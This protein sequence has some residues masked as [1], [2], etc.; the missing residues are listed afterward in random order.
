[1]LPRSLSHLSDRALAEQLE[2]LVSRERVHAA[3]LLAHLAEFDAR[4]LYRPAGYA[5][6]YVYC[7]KALG[8]SEDVACRRTIAARASR[9]HPTILAAL[10]DGRLHLSAVVT[11]APYLKRLPRQAA[12]ALLEAAERRSKHDL[13]LM[14][15]TRFPSPDVPT[16]VR[17]VMPASDPAATERA[18]LTTRPDAPTSGSALQVTPMSCT[19]APA[20]ISDVSMTSAPPFGPPS[21]AVPPQPPPQQ[22]RAQVVPLSAERFE[23]RGTI[24]CDFHEKIQKLRELFSHVV[25]NGD[26]FA[27]LERCADEVL[28]RAERRG[29]TRASRVEADGT[30]LAIDPE[31]RQ[32]PEALRR[33]IWHRDGGQCTFV[34]ESGRRCESRERVELDHVVPVAKGGRTEAGNLRLLC[35]THNQF[36]AERQLGPEFIRQRRAHAAQQREFERASERATSRPA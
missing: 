14:L 12:V 11:L 25:P 17:P 7:V 9:R 13:A 27:L 23:L 31:H 15:A 3:E 21:L 24:S 8:M 29:T 30:P 34:S 33:F 6:L 36:E 4:K 20:R 32:A 28:A 18:P 16:S 2:T 35:R 19:S 1:M 5:S 10:A 22:I 26:A